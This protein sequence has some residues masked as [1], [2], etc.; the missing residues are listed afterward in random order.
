[1]TANDLI[2][3]TFR[4]FDEE[5][6]SKYEQDGDRTTALEIL[7]DGYL[8]VCIETKCKRTTTP[9]I[10]TANN[11]ESDQP[12]DS[13]GIFSIE[14]P[15][16]YSYLNPVGRDKIMVNQSGTPSGYTLR[17]NKIVWDVIP[18]TAYTY[19]VDYAQ[20]PTAE[21][22][23]TEEPILIPEMWQPRIL[24]YY[25]LK[26]LFAIDKREE[27]L[28]R[29]PFWNGKYEEKLSKMRSFYSSGMYAGKK[30][31]LG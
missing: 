15:S 13:V 12:V 19:N 7:N 29:A 6:D 26:E 31:S 8:E 20:G 4:R 9:I 10:T 22:D 23:L 16:A 30:P 21:L 27:V 2:S 14:H 3:R 18:V 1:M 5:T 25:I 17:G 11:R 24:P 28:A